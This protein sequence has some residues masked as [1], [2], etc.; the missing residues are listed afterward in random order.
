MRIAILSTFPPTACGIGEYAAQQARH[1]EAQG[2]TVE[3]VRLEELREKGWRTGKDGA[4]RAALAAVDR[5]D[6][7]IVHYQIG[8]LKD[9]SR[10]VRGLGYFAPQA[11][12]LRLLRRAGKKGEVVVH[13]SSY[14]LYRGPGEFV[15]YPV[16]WV[17]HRAAHRLVFHTEFERKAF[18]ERFFRHPRAEVR[19]HHG[20]FTPNV[21]A[22]RA[23]A[24]QRLG[25]PAGEHVTL[26]IGFYTPSKGFPEFAE[27]FA[28]ALADGTLPKDRHLH[29]VTS[30][31]VPTD[32]AAQEG[33][34]K[35]E[36]RWAGH[37]N[38][39][40]R[41]QFVS[42]EEFDLWVLASDVVA[43]PYTSTFSSGVAARARLLGRRILAAAVG[44]LPEQ[45]G[46][47]DLAY[48]GPDG[49]RAAFRA[50]AAS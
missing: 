29:V 2:H 5:A 27:A 25:L 17:V 38:L 39:H 31:R 1:L 10:R 40:V 24:R 32:R 36:A 21:E 41:N 11:G 8:L 43:L 16:S 22:D 20:E 47:G 44:G 12:L 33:L 28:A 48:D 23:T 34:A 19:P 49:L 46:P 45:L 3:R 14:K 13:E 18:E 6:R 30:V 9:E 35:L 15:Q 42:P 37:P 7:V 4:L 50:I 26:C